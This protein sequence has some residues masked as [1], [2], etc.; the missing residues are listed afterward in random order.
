MN[1]PP[2]EKIERRCLVQVVSRYRAADTAT[3]HVMQQVT[4]Q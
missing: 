2:A 3:D 4:S 1:T